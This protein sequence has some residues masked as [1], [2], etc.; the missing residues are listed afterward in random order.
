MIGPAGDD[1]GHFLQKVAMAPGWKVL[2][3]PSVTSTNDLA[4]EA[5][6]RGWSDR[7]VF[8]ADYQTAGR[9]RQG[10]T[11]IAPPRTS[12]LMSVLLRRGGAAPYLYT[13][14]ASV[15]V[16]EAAE[17][18]L[19][20][21]PAIK[22]PNDVMVDDR[23]A[24]GIL[25]EASD[26]GVERTVVIGVGINVNLDQ[27]QMAA[28]PNATSLALAAGVPVHRGELLVLILER[29]DAW[30]KVGDAQLSAALWPAWDRRLWGRSQRVSLVEGAETLEGVILGGGPDGTLWIRTPD[31]RE[32]RVVA[33]EILP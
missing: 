30:L 9:G 5:A 1:L 17:R 18:L 14:L 8:V 10:R 12:L 7:S 13:M 20:L 33:G 6:R 22:W 16:C 21:A 31:G 23:K 3:E 28:V 26:D 11:W 27:E 32:R 29:M 15:A 4:R 19:A 2:F 24:A 25:A